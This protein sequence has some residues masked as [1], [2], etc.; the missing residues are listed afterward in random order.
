MK[1]ILL[2]LLLLCGTTMFANAQD[3]TKK[4]A[5]FEW[6][7]ASLREIGVEDDKIKKIAK[8]KKDFGKTRTKIQEDD[9]L[10]AKA[11]KTAIKSATSERN[12]AL[13]AVLTAEQL[14]KVD[15]INAKLKEEAKTSTK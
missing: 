9:S 1:R 12:A 10:D 5:A 11:K 3:A 13:R 7:T 15:E 6:K 2:M 8:I 14:K 4:A